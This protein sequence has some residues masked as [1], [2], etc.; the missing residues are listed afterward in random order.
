GERVAQYN[1]AVMLAKGDGVEQDNEAALAW[2]CK[3]AEQQLPEAEMML[4][5]L[6]AAGR[7]TEAD[8]A[9]ARLWYER[10]A[11]HGVVAARARLATVAAIA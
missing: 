9:T 5:D 8:P 6:I 1:L 10:A 7:G 11:A 2:C 4:G 3:A